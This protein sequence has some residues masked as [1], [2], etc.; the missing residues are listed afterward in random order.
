MFPDIASNR[1]SQTDPEQEVKV[2]TDTAVTPS[3]TA[4]V[5]RAAALVLA[6]LERAERSRAFDGYGLIEDDDDQPVRRMFT[7]RLGARSKNPGEV[8]VY[9]EREVVCVY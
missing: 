6:E 9:A 8:R 1:Q 2:A 5:K 7:L 3:L 4:F